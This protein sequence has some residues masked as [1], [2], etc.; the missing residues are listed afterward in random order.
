MASVFVID[1]Y[2]KTK[3]FASNVRKEKQWKMANVPAEKM[4]IEAQ[5]LVQT[6]ESSSKPSS[7]SSF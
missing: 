7:A 3:H 5:K 2:Q 6:L 4:K 1:F